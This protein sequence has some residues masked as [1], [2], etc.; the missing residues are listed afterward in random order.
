MRYKIKFKVWLEKDKDIVMGL[1][2]DKLLREI[3][4][5]GSISKAAK[6]VGMSY[7]KAWSF[8]KAME[9]RLG[10][11]LIQT[12]RGGKGGGGAVLTK[13]AKNLLNEFEKITKEFEKLTEK[14]SKNE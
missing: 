11:K 3:D 12:Q 13:E 6:E 7:K 1:G 10:I 8:I 9:K 5:L 2:R 14:L 4:R